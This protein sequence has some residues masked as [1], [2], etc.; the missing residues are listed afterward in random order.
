V[1]VRFAEF[2]LDLDRRLLLRGETS[3]HLAPKTLDLLALLI[4]RRPNAVSKEELFRE[5]WPETFVTDNVLATLVT[6]IRAAIGDDARKPRWLRTAR[7]FGYAFIG[8]VHD[9]HAASDVTLAPWFLLRDHR[10]IPLHEGENIVGRRGAGL[11]CFDSPT[12]SKRHARFAVASGR[13]TVEDLGSKNGTWV[14]DRR[15]DG[16]T[17]VRDGDQ[18]RLGSV[19][20]TACVRRGAPSTDTVA[21]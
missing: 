7:G 11:V 13:L 12:V 16:P 10:E 1:N 20:I 18:V 17:V 3:L 15:I 5:L 19:L 4:Q 14:G 2:T 6:D 21:N 9:D 8:E